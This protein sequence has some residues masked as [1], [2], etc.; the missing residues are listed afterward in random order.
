M[1]TVVGP[2]WRPNPEIPKARIWLRVVATLIDV[3]LF[4][5]VSMGVVFQWGHKVGP[6]MWQAR[7]GPACA[8]ILFSSVY[9]FLLR[10]TPGKLLCD[11]RIRSTDGGDV[12]YHR[13][14]GRN[15]LKCLEW[16][17]FFLPSFLMVVSNPER[18]SPPD[19][20]ARTIV[21]EEAA[22]KRWQTGARDLPFDD[23]LK[24][25]KAAAVSKTR[26][27]GPA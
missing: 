23:W 3:V 27:G 1:S 13:I 6:M 21:V 10:S 4:M 25:M 26:D 8:G 17:I 19:R 14:V 15:C 5:S 18:Q 22:F 20:A 7:G 24:S 11:L 12:P 9:L 16:P 2:P